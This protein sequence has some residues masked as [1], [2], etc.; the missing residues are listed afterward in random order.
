MAERKRKRKKKRWEKEEVLDR[1]MCIAEEAHLA[2]WSERTDKS[3]QSVREYDARCATIEL[4]A[5][6]YAVKL[7]GFDLPEGEELCV[8]LEEDAKELAK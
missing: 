2:T 8:T 4:K 3:G 7:A 1:L 6:E 5:L